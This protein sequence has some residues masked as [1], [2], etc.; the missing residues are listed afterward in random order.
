MKLNGFGYTR[1]Q[2][3]S[4]C[5]DILQ[6][7]G[8]T[9]ARLTDG[10]A[11]GVKIVSVRTGAGLSF[12]VSL[13]RCLDIIQADYCGINLGYL[14][15]CNVTHPSYYDERDCES[16]R[17]FFGGLL[18]TCGLTNTGTPS[19]GVGLHG[20]I[21]NTPAEQVV[22]RNY[23][24]DDR[25]LSQIQGTMREAA[26][27]SEKLF[28]T[29]TITTELGKNRILIEDDIYNAGFNS[30][31]WMLMYHIN[32]GFPLLDE[33]A[34]IVTYPPKRITPVDDRSTE[35]MDWLFAFS[36]PVPNCSEYAYQ[37]L[38]GTNDLGETAYAAVNDQLEIGLMVSYSIDALPYV[39]YWKMPGFSDY[40]LGYEPS[41][42]PSIG[43]TAAREQGVLPQIAPG[44]HKK[45]SL[46]LDVMPC[47]EIY[48]YFKNVF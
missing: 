10:R 3:E 11:D 42:C 4:L 41:I 46:Q 28:L 37:I 14:S 17:Q 12:V 47:K 35:A 6:L 1:R 5:G 34:K 20:R 30:V 15:S 18:S 48:K 29:R 40:V 44:E 36:K 2:L 21:G 31:E 33:K 8:A 26:L 25:F 9:E 38:P 39:T 13:D 7:G 24:E 45:I 16:R 32:F 23:W 43:R 19:E 27:F 22:V